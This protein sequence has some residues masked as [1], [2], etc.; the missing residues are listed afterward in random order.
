MEMT[1]TITKIAGAA[2]LAFAF[3]LPAE[4]AKL[5]SGP[6]V[7]FGGGTD[8]LVC[9]VLNAGSSAKNI[10]SL[11][12]LNTEGSAVISATCTGNLGPRKICSVTLLPAASPNPVYSC[13]LT[14]EGTSTS[15]LRGEFAR[16]VDGSFEYGGSQPL[17]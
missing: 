15:G 2:L 13:Q 6:L 11:R 4:A 16:I 5:T 3:T 17:R 14:I 10:Q 8:V 12:I 7:G 1:M 9:S